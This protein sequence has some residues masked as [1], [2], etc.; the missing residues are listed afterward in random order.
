MDRKPILKLTALSAALAGGAA[1]AQEDPVKELTRPASEVSLGAGYWN[2]DR[3]RLGTYDGMPDKGAYGLLDALIVTRDEAGQW[4][5][6][7]ARNPG[8]DTREFRTDWERQG[9][10]GIFMEYSQTPR[11]EPYT[12]LTGVTGIGTTTQRVPTPSATRLGAIHLGTMREAFGAGFSKIIGGGFDFRFSAKSEDKRG[13]RLWGRGGTTEFAAE[14]IDSN[15]RQL[16]AAL[17]YARQA[18]QITGGYYGSWYTNRNSLVDTANISAAGVLSNQ[19]VLSQPLDN[20]AHQLY[21]NGGYNLSERTRATFKVSYQRITQDEPIPVG[22]GVAVFSGAPASL[23]GRL[24]NTL[25]QLGITSRATKDFSWLASL[26]SYDS[27]EK[28]P[29]ARIVQT[30]A[31]CPTCVDTTPLTVKTLTGKLEGTYRLP[32]SFSGTAGVDLSKQDRN[33]PVGNVNPATGV[34]AQR[35]VPWRS[36]LQETTLRLELRRSLAETLNGRVVY[37]HGKRDGDEFTPTNEAQSDLINPIHLA[38]RDRDKIKLVLDWAPTQALSFNFNIEHAQD[39]YGHSGS[40]PYGLR[41]GSASLFSLDAAYSFAESWQLTAFYSRDQ[42]KAT[43]LGQRNANSGAGEAVKEA[44]LEDIGDTLGVGVRGQAMAKLKIG[45]DLLYQ[46]NVNKYP[47]TITLTGAGALYPTQGGATAVGPLPDITNKMTRLKLN[48]T[49][50]LQKTSEL[51][52]EYT[53]ELWKTNDWS[54]MFADGTTPF[55]YSGTTAQSD[56]TQVIQAPKQSA[57]WFGVRYTYRFQ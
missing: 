5:R 22:Q 9:D 2:H 35:Y 50:A 39:D 42:T 6:L 15:T 45:A 56:G 36:E 12:V 26:R 33:V 46:K 14:P 51:R 37:A 38:D 52:F 28:T 20:T 1:W 23:D 8:L 27:D 44:K 48:A 10:F 18:F 29:Q 40:R 55:T 7:D 53:H 30:G 47:E 24:D 19:F 34:D 25:M 11:D 21:V 49:Y 3:P 31:P 13:D 16:E 32:Q 17:S 41:D 43:Q 54:W 4:F 57:D